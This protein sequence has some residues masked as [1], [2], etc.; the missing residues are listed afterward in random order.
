MR[1]G[2]RA[3][4]SLGRKVNKPGDWPDHSHRDKG[5]ASE[6]LESTD[7]GLRTGWQD[8]LGDWECWRSPAQAK[9]EAD[10]AC[11][12]NYLHSPV[13]GYKKKRKESI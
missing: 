7:E 9:Q 6:W 2:N 12:G 11:T 3:E 5:R 10:V 13:P 4:E 8:Q 1:G